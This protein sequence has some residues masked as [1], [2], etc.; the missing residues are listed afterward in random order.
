MTRCAVNDYLCIRFDCHDDPSDG[1]PSR[2]TEMICPVRSLVCR[3]LAQAWLHVRSD[4]YE[5]T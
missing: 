2:Q 3:A 1:K 5:R 4:G